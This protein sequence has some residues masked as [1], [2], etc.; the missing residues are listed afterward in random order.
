MKKRSLL[1]ALGMIALTSCGQDVALALERTTYH[2][3]TFADNMYQDTVL[4]TTL[5]PAHI[6]NKM[7][8]TVTRDDLITG[9]TNVN[10][11]DRYVT[12]NGTPTLVNDDLFATT[13]KLSN[14][15]TDVKYGFESKLFDGILHCSDAIRISKSRLQ[16]QASGFGY[17]FNT[18]L[19][20]ANLLGV[21]LKAGADTF[22]GGVAITDV[23]VKL[24]YYL[25]TTNLEFIQ[26]EFNLDVFGI[27]RLDFPQ[28]YGFYLTDVAPS[29]SLQG[30]T[31]VS[32][33]YE[34]LD[35]AAQASDPH[36]TAIFVYEVML[37]K[38]TW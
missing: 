1:I 3:A 6:A 20:S 22:S 33:Q 15:L 9:V 23:R 30:A 5:A 7:T 26:H 2:T 18:P 8:Y 14:S 27:R 38:S 29:L 21:Y 19:Q 11:T 31:A 16:I 35:A 25:P 24:S 28:F 17:V 12:V 4:S 37:P 34:I 32:V 36:Y 10:E 13:Y